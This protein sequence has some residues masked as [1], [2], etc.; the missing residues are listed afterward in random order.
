MLNNMYFWDVPVDTIHKFK[1]QLYY[2]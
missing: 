2:F 1:Y